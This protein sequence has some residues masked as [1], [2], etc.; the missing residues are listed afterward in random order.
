MDQTELIARTFVSL[1]DT[2]VGDFDVVD[3]LD[4]L[5][6]D[7]ARILDS[8]AAGVMLVDGHKQLQVM[9]SSDPRMHAIEVLQLQSTEGPCLDAFHRRT[10]VHAVTAESQGRWTVFAP[11]ALAEGYRAVSAFPLRLREQTIGALNVFRLDPAPL[12]PTE[13]AIAQGLADVATIALVQHQAL[14][15]SQQLAAQL[16]GALNSRVVIEQAKGLLAEGAHV[17]IDDAF[18]AIRRYS[19]ETNARLT[20]VAERLVNGH[21]AAHNVVPLNRS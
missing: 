6:H 16:Q 2:M 11:R 14:R 12:S 5:V 19:R 9:A 18:A 13:T 20:D 17:S 21:L 8:S 7:T 1:A 15:E 4:R 3:L 10:P